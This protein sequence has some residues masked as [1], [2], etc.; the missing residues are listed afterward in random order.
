MSAAALDAADL[1]RQVIE[2]GFAVLGAAI[3]PAAVDEFVAQLRQSLPKELDLAAPSSWPRGGARRVIEVAPLGE[4]PQW[5][6][7]CASP[8]LTA[9]LDALLGAGAWQL[10]LNRG[11]ADGSL[12]GPRHWYAPIVLSESPSSPPPPPRAVGGGCICGGA[13]RACPFLPASAL[14]AAAAAAPPAACVAWA[15][16]SRRRW[17]G[18][19]WHLDVGPGFANDEVRRPCG[20][21]RQGVVLLLLLSDCAAG[22]GGTALLPGSHSWV[23]AELVRAEAAGEQLP[24]HEALNAWAVARLRAL[25]E[26]GR[27]ALP[28]CGAGAAAALPQ[29][30]GGADGM[31][32]VEQVV[33]RAGDLVLMHPLLLHTGTTNCSGATRLMINGMCTINEQA[34]AAQQHPLMQALD[35]GSG[36]R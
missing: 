7:L 30:W 29:P 24:T 23:H 11:A 34:W 35:A 6:A 19:G 21:A 31:L 33:G 26:S 16:V 22:G 2:R 25:T 28:P 14:P 32:H 36:S 12:A 13:P 1:R 20:D 17:A 4:G 18:L 9:A 8:R 15:P 5:R 10:P 3:E 27:V